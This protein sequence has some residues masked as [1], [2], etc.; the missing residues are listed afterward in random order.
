MAVFGLILSDPA[1]SPSARASALAL[2]SAQTIPCEGFTDAP[3][4]IPCGLPLPDF[5]RACSAA[6][7]MPGVPL[8][9]ADTV[10]YLSAGDALPGNVLRRYLFLQLSLLP[11]LRRDAGVHPTDGGFFLGPDLL[12]GR[13]NAEDRVDLSLPGG[14]WTDIGCGACYAGPRLRLMRGYNAMPVLAR[15]GALIPVGV[16]DRQVDYDDA[17]RVTLHW[18]EPAGEAECTLA[19]GE[20]Y[21]AFWQGRRA[22]VV[23]STD[24][25]CHLVVHQSGQE[26]LAL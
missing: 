4:P 8:P 21:R 22:V 9:M 11:Y 12:V 26:T 14:V 18:F 17:D 2:L 20:R 19:G 16:N 1:Q 13:V 7:L 6:L 23:K 25:P 10:R 24:K 3:S 15:P 5:L